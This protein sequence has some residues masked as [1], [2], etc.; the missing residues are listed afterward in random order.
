MPAA[1]LHPLGFG[2]IL[3]GAFTLYRRNFLAVFSIAL[4]VV[5]P[6]TFLVA[7]MPTATAPDAASTSSPGEAAAAI[8]AGLL[9]FVLIAILWAALVA[10]T[11]DASN[12]E[13][14]SI[15][16]SYA[17][18]ARALPSVLG[19]SLLLMLIFTALMIA[20]GLAW[21][22]IA[23]VAAPFIQAPG[24]GAGAWVFVAVIAMAT[25]AVMIF[26]GASLFAVVPAIMAERLGPW[27]AIR[28]S[29]QLA[30]GGRF[31]IMGIYFVASLIVVLPSLGLG[32]VLGLQ[33]G[34]LD[35]GTSAT[36]SPTQ[37]YLEQIVSILVGA[38]TAPFPIAAMTLLYFDRRVRTEAYDLE[39]AADNLAVSG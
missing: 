13:K 36:L 29:Y 34:L 30:R 4:L 12:G 31:R 21:G 38:L 32:I 39:V 28:R 24:E 6:M 2:E 19:A 20:V 17:R 18:A 11:E 9:A 26:A 37:L 35:P 3:D 25:F 27:N 7:A 15:G 1:K 14:V 33:Q 5:I 16:S 23:L 10:A 8:V 22:A